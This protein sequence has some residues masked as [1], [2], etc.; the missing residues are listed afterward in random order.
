MKKIFVADASG[1]PADFRNMW[2]TMLYFLYQYRVVPLL[3]EKL[4]CK[5]NSDSESHHRCKM[6]ALWAKELLQSLYK[7]KR[8]VELVQNWERERQD[9]LEAQK[10]KVYKTLKRNWRRKPKTK[11]T[12]SHIF[13]RMVKQ[14]EKL[15]PDLREVMSLRIQKLPRRLTELQ[16]LR[17]ATLKPSPHTTTF[18]PW[19]V[20]YYAYFQRG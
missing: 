20:A 2:Q 18:L 6:A 15:N 14:V 1:L 19:Y 8:T 5:S 7:V 13:K 4:I 11:L 9:G 12:A 3:V 16:F 10:V 17:E